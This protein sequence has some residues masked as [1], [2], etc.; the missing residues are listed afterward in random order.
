MHNPD[1][2]VDFPLDDSVASKKARIIASLITIQN[3]KGPGVGCPAVS[4]TLS[5]QLAALG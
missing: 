5:Q 4:T 3:L 1:V 2:K